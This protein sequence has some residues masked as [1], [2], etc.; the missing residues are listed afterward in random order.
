MHRGGKGWIL[1]CM[2]GTVALLLSGL[3]PVQAITKKVTAAYYPDWP[4]TFEYGWAKGWFDRKLGVQ[5]P[6]REFGNGPDTTTAMASG[7]VSTAYAPGT[8]PFT[9][10]V[11]QGLPIKLV[12]ISG[13]Y[14]ESEN[15]VSR[16]GTHII[17]PRDLIGKKIGV[18]F[19][20]TSHYRLLGMLRTFGV[21]ENDVQIIDLRNPNVLSAFICK[22]ID[23]GC[24]WEPIVS[25]MIEHGGHILVSSQDQIRWGYSTYG[26]VVV[27]SAFAKENP[28]LLVKFLQVVNDSTKAFKANPEKTYKLI[29]EKAGLTAEKTKQIM[30]TMGFYTKE[31]QLR[32]A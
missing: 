19:G 10:A 17:S 14:S 30:S 5:V 4:G 6:F 29:A 22:D 23:A 13:N 8:T 32:S 31:E 15:L 16:N 21:S 9:I 11:A 2:L 24:G 3:G 26:L 20:S 28:Q 1:G 27:N 25:Q 7:D 12:G 18:S